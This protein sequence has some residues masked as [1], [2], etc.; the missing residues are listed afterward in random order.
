M[1]FTYYSIAMGEDG[2]THQPVEQ[3]VGSRS[4]PGMVVL[5]PAD[6]NE[7]VAVCGSPLKGKKVRWLSVLTRQ[8][9]PV[10][11]LGHYPG[12]PEGSAAG[13]AHV[14]AYLSPGHTTTDLLRSRLA[15]RCIWRWRAASDWRVT[16]CSRALRACRVQK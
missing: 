11:D 16:A 4:I 2:P 9:L 13:R 3:L 7:T 12:I 6:A 5:R 15:P 8:G 1:C 10:L 14:L